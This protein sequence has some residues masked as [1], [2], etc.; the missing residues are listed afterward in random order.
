MSVVPKS[1]TC[2]QLRYST[3]R[4]VTLQL[5]RLLPPLRDR[6]VTIALHCNR[7]SLVTD[8]LAA[9]HRHRVIDFPT[10]ETALLGSGAGGT[11]GHCGGTIRE[12]LG[13]LRVWGHWSGSTSRRYSIPVVSSEG[14]HSVADCNEFQ[15]GG[16]ETTTDCYS[17][18]TAVRRYMQRAAGQLPCV[19]NSRGSSNL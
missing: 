1:S 15:D 11:H 14:T 10:D 4:L 13:V 18:F 16:I 12:V 3:S 17:S 5:L 7:Y 19:A 8:G 9:K 2:Q 6:A